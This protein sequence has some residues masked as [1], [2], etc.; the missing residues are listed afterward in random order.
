MAGSDYCPICGGYVPEG[1]MVCKQCEISPPR[2][3]YIYRFSPEE[4][5]SGLMLCSTGDCR[6]CDYKDN[7]KDCDAL[8]RDAAH[9]LCQLLEDKNN[10]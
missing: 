1:R 9:L 5:V 4:I 10:V 8:S 2:P 3:K 6:R 7:H